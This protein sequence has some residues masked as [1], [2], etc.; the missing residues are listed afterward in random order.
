[1]Y[2]QRYMNWPIDKKSIAKKESLIYRRVVSSTL[3]K[4]L[5]LPGGSDLYGLPIKWTGWVGPTFQ[6]LSS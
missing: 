3:G 4:F 5:L 6:W 1:M 2:I